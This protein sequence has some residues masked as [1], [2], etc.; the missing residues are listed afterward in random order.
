VPKAVKTHITK[1]VRRP[2]PALTELDDH[3]KL[4]RDFSGWRG[5]RSA[6]LQTAR[7]CGSIREFTFIA[8]RL[9]VAVR[10]DVPR[11]SLSNVRVGGEP[12]N[13]YSHGV[14]RILTQSRRNVR[15]QT[16]DGLL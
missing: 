9:H 2:D 10:L 6:R 1:P 11:R 15:T 3:Q 14:F 13:I 16:F 7:R 4:M 5:S 12:E 8:Q